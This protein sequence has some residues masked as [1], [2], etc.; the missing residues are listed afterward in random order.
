MDRTE[1]LDRYTWAR[2]ENDGDTVEKIARE[3]TA[4]DKAHP[5][6]PP[7]KPLLIDIAL[8]IPMNTA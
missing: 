6:Q 5:D 3:V 2:L 8:R 4:Y 7:I 1:I